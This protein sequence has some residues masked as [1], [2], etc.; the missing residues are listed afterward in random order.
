MEIGF[1]FRVRGYQFDAR[2]I[3]SRRA[4]T[5]SVIPEPSTALPVITS[6]G[7]ES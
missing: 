1:R 6:A 5:L 3:L 2:V 7:G 4:A